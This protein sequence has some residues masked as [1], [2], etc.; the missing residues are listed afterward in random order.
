MTKERVEKRRAEALILQAQRQLKEVALDFGM[1]FER[2]RRQHIE[3]LSRE[4]R[5]NLAQDDDWRIDHSYADLQDAL[6][7]LNQQVCVY[8]TEDEQ[9]DLWDDD[10]WGDKDDNTGGSAPIPSPRRPDPRP[11]TNEGAELPPIDYEPPHH[12]GVVKA[13]W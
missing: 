13:G 3:T 5:E 2:N 6:F 11:G 9:D 7:E 4:L 1:Q 8:Y 10:P 12:E